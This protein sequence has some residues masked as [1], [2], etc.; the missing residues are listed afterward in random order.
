MASYRAQPIVLE[1]GEN[2][3]LAW[4]SLQQAYSHLH[5][6]KEI[7]L[8]YMKSGQVLDLQVHGGEV[9]LEKSFFA[10]GIRNKRLLG[11]WS[12]EHH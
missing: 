8:L 3:S 2:S 10:I 5:K 4:N 1:E 7:V 11:L 12:F 9:I 6:A